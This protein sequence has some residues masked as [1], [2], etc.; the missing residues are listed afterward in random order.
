MNILKVTYN[1]KAYYGELPHSSIII[2][3]KEEGEL[4]I[5]F[6][7]TDE[8]S[9]PDERSQQVEW[10]LSGLSIGDRLKIQIVEDNGER[11]EPLDLDSV[12]LAEYNSLKKKLGK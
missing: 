2:S 1:G 3:N 6:G 7:G 9:Q 5:V 4:R 10:L 8:R 12:Y 11:S